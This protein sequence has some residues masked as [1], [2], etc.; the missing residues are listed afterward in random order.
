MLVATAARGRFRTTARSLATRLLVTSAVAASVL[1]GTVSQSPDPTP[2]VGEEVIAIGD[3]ASGWSAGFEPS[4]R[5][6]MVGFTWSAPTSVELQVRGRSSDGTWSEWLDLHGGLAEAPERAETTD[7]SRF[8]GPAWLG[9]DL[10]RIEV[11]GPA[12]AISAL[13][14][15]V[16]D[17]EPA[18]AGALT[19]PSATALP[20][21]PGIIS[22]AQWGADES[23]RSVNPDCSQ[24]RYSNDV[25]YVVIH[26]TVN[27]NNY[28]AADSAA[29]IR[30]I[31]RFHV[32]T[33]GWCD[34]A[35]N[36]LVDRFGQVFE[37]RAGGIRERVIGGHS[38]GFNTGSTGIAMLG[39]FQEGTVPQA[40]YNSLRRLMAFKMGHHG[41]DPLG[42]TTVHTVEHSSSR[43]PAGQDIVVQT[44][45][46][47]GDLS[48][49]TC[50]GQY[51]RELIPRLRRD[52]ASDIFWN[53]ADRRVVGDWDG[54]GYDTVGNFENGYWGLRNS[55]NPGAPDV[56]IH[57]GAAGYRPVVGDWDGNG[58]DTIGVYVGDTWYL[59]NSNT[60]GPPD[61]VI[62]Y[63]WPEVT[64]VVG[65]WDG[66]GTDTIGIYHRGT[67]MLRDQN[68]AGLPQRWFDYGWDG[69]QPVVGDWN[70]DGTDGIGIFWSGHWNLRQAAKPGNPEIAFD[71]RT[72]T[73]ERPVAGD[74][75]RDGKD[76]P[77]SFRG[78]YWFLRNSLS[79]GGPNVAFWY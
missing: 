58:T 77:G 63:G 68:S 22:R 1:T 13:E 48:Q 35:Y 59:R 3:T 45:V 50:P 44:V 60:P 46:P 42:T 38:G 6:E 18:A 37:G 56:S 30:G 55:Q 64:P 79:A 34:I 28:S 67:W 76:D 47:H 51:L 71:Y 7:R 57:Y 74:W 75:N 2:P 29:L 43:F 49:T 39:D 5:G 12:H 8:A 53:S 16:M 73:G 27:A 66:N 65:D 11:R 70:G 24:P 52:V 78:A 21:A 26:H 54:D 25:T 14:M 31:Y 10:D 23:W 40:T 36:F 33:N 32:Y 4:S 62:R 20:A 15:H 69:P 41:I 72:L 19:A 17:S 61:I 9:H